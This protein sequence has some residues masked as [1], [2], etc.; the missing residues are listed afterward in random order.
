MI[1]DKRFTF[2]VNRGLSE[3]ADLVDAYLR[4]AEVPTYRQIYDF[5]T[6]I[7]AVDTQ[8][9]WGGRVDYS[10]QVRQ[11]V[12]DVDL[13]AFDRC[14]AQRRTSS[15]VDVHCHTFTPSSF[16]DLFERVA[17]LGLL[18]YRLSDF[19]PTARAELEF[20]AT[21]ELLDPSMSAAR[22]LQAQAGSFQDARRALATAAVPDV[23]ITVDDQPGPDEIS[24]KE[25]RL[26]ESKRRVM[27]AVWQVRRQVFGR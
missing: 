20:Y 12:V 9:L 7:I 18:D 15:Y 21:F 25:R 5:F 11:D 4:S 10:N 6:K 27:G 26:I 24:A 14:I 2:D 3:V 19:R 1:P 13:D 22:R 17:S 23:A 16:L 8:A